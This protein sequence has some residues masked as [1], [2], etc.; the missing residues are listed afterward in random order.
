MRGLLILIVTIWCAGATASDTQKLV[1]LDGTAHTIGDFVGRGRWVM[2][3]IWSPGCSHCLVELPTLRRFHR[4][5]D[6]NA[7]VLGVAVAY[8]GF[9]YP[10][11]DAIDA[12]ATINEIDFPL[13]LADGKTAS[14]FVGEPVDVV[15]MTFAFHPDGRMVARWHGVITL[16]D[17]NEIIRDFAGRQ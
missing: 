1:G 15:P 13:L 7:M 8:P 16:P 14:A 2:V 11:R 3:N 4:E 17:I 12:F 6:A 10:D 5:N 9:G